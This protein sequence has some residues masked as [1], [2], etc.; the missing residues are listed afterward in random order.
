[1]TMGIMKLCSEIVALLGFTQRGFM[2]SYRYFRT[3]LGLIMG[4]G[5]KVHECM[6]IEM[7]PL[8]YPETSEVNNQSKPCNI[9]GE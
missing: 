2:F 8:S 1:M 9:P 6:S 7:V 5:V 4:L 3:N